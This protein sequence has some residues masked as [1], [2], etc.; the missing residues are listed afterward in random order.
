M[1]SLKFFCLQTLCPKNQNLRI[2]LKNS[3]GKLTKRFFSANF[4]RK[5]STYVIAAA[6][7]I[8]TVASCITLEK[9]PE[10][11]N[12]IQHEVTEDGTP[13]W[14]WDSRFSDDSLFFVA[15]GS[16]RSNREEEKLLALENAALQAGV[17]S[18]FWGSSQDFM[19]S[20]QQG[21]NFTGRTRA[22]YDGEAMDL[23][24]KNMKAREIWVTEEGTWVKF[25]LERPEIPHL[26][27][28][29]DYVGGK[30]SWINKP[31]VIPGWIVTVGLGAEQSTLVRTFKR[32]DE[33]A[34]AAMILRIHGENSSMA[35]EK[36]QSSETWSRTEISS[37]SYGKGFGSIRG[38]VVIA[39]WHDK[40][41]VWSLAVCPEEWN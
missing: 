1:N 31:P 8:T 12:P 7:L 37:A 4:R 28:Q 5:W 30:P 36:T 16:R 29:P 6:V 35:I 34:L 26:N 21:A 38:F 10:E 13:L 9:S 17:F 25:Q 19:I 14:I 40:S 22:Y 32:A 33:A 24:M 39:R 41:G 11:S 15:A 3:P 20:N 23:A 27:W 18:E 2:L